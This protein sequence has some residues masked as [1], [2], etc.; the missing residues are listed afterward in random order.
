MA[1]P[2]FLGSGLLR[3]FARDK[4][5]DFANDSG[6]ALV[7]ACIG[8]I[9]GTRGS[10]DSGQHQGELEWRPAFGSKLYLLQHRKGPHLE[11]LAAYYVAEALQRWEPRVT[12][13]RATATFD[14]LQRALNVE[15]V[16]DVIAANVSTNNVSQSVAVPLA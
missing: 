16:Y 5:N 4:K 9:L 2:A 15:L 14:P 3:P 13:V 11:E 8:Q 7:K 1:A 6:L 10:D 12:N